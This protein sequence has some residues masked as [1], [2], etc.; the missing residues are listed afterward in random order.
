MRVCIF[1]AGNVAFHLTH[2][3]IDAGHEVFVWNRSEG[4][5]ASMIE[6]GAKN[7]TTRIEDIPKD[8]DLYLIS[9]KDDAVTEVLEMLRGHLPSNVNVAHTAGSLSVEIVEKR[10]VNC[11]VLYPMQT[12]T[13]G[14]DLKYCEIPFFIEEKGEMKGLV[15]AL[16]ESVSDKVYELN[17]SQRRYLHLASVFACNFV[18][19]CYTLSESVLSKI[20]L[21]FSVMLPLVDETV[22]KVKQLNSPVDC[23]TGPAVR[24]D[25]MVMGAQKELLEDQREKDIYD[26]M[27]LSIIDYKHK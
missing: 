2:A 12:F 14:K 19:H 15:R 27:S 10:F 24:E 25:A 13:K 8:I 26:L 4:A 3:F 11:G 21:P 5:L 16:A 6:L 1:G 22:A 20:G 18:N 17:S 9:V 23:Q 7:C